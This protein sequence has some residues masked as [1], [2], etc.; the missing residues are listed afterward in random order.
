MKDTSKVTRREAVAMAGA[1]TAA[2]VVAK[3]Y[4]TEGPFIRKV[5]AANDQVQY[6]IIGTGGRGQY[7]IKHFNKLD[8]GRCVA[9]C[10]T[11]DVNLQAA[12]KASKD[13]PVGIKDY[14]ELLSRKDI[15]AV[16]ISTPLFT[17]FPITR[18]ALLAGKHVFCE[19]SMV[20]KP[21]EVHGLRKLAE[22]HPKQVVQCGLQRRYSKFYQTAKQ[23]VEKGTIGQVTHAYAQWNRNPGWTMKPDK[24]LK[25]QKER[26]WRLY[27]ETSGGLVAELAS[28]QIDVCDWMF[29]ATP[30]FVVG[31]GDLTWRK[32]GRDVYDNAQLI[33]KYP[34]NQKLMYSTISTNKHL[35]LFNGGR[36]E[37]GEVIMGTEGTIEI[38]VGTDDE[39]AVGLWFYEPGPKL[40]AA[41]MKKQVA[42]VAGATMASTGRGSR[43]LPILFDKDTL[44]GKES[45]IEKEMKFARR[46]LYSKGVMVPEEDRNP[47]T[48]QLDHFLE[49]CRTGKKP[50]ADVEIGLADSSMVILANLALDEGRRVYFNEMDKMGKKA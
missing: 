6:A 27:R 45:F 28:H 1:A 42:A 35:T 40:T 4:I 31:V 15:D 14:R 36:T 50:L 38:T 11:F 33:F 21:E 39:P 44:S 46:W 49:C 29:N 48:V 41:E 16:I 34:K 2:A 24:D 8:S 18:D 47:C 3:K 43:A 12:L 30:E 32:D 13:K 5:K 25:V 10:D 7:H 22:E 23:M 19:K 17:H 9:L 26:N 37:F 20:F